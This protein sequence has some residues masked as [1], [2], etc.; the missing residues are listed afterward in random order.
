[1]V[2]RKA[3]LV[4]LPCFIA[5]S[6]V[7]TGVS[8]VAATT[9]PN[10]SNFYEQLSSFSQMLFSLYCLTVPLIQAS[11]PAIRSF[12]L[13]LAVATSAF[14]GTFSVV[15]FYMSQQASILLSFVSGTAQIVA[16]ILLIEGVDEVV[17]NPPPESTAY[18]RAASRTFED[19]VADS[20]RRAHDEEAVRPDLF[21]SP[22]ARSANG[23]T[24]F[25][26]KE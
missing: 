23:G 20:S 1:M 19:E 21:Y 5:F 22:M 2:D 18:P 15:L 9:D 3:I 8:L 14:A 11:N 13:R 24:L 16:T 7:F 25:H 10:T 12:W 4:L 17:R 26:P 6:A